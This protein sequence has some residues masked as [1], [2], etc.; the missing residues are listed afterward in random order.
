MAISLV[1][2]VGKIGAA[3]T[4]ITTGTLGTPATAGNLLVAV[5]SVDKD[6]GG[7]AA[8]PSDWAALA[9]RAGAS[10]SLQVVA[11][12]AAGG[13]TA[14]TLS[15]T[16]S[17]AAT[18]VIAEFS[19]VDPADPF[20]PS[21]FPAY[22]D[23][24]STGVTL[25]PGPAE[26]AGAALVAL[27]VDSGPLTAATGPGMTNRSS[28]ADVTGAPGSALLY[29]TDIAAG[30]DL[31]PAVY[32][33]PAL[34]DQYQGF[35]VLLNA[36]SASPQV[37]VPGV[38][39]NVDADSAEAVYRVTGTTSARLVVSTASD[40]SS[41]VY[42]TAVGPDP[43][44]AVKLPVAGLAADTLYHYGVELNGVL[45]PGFRGSFRTFPSSAPATFRFAMSSCLRTDLPGDV[46]DQVRAVS[47]RFFIE[48]GDF[49]YPDY[50]TNDPGR[51][52]DHYDVMLA[53][54]K[55]AA[56][57]A[58]FPFFYAF[59][60]H[61]YGNDSA[62]A[63]FGPNRDSPSRPAVNAAYRERFPHY[64]L[65]APGGIGIYQTFTYGPDV[66]FIVLDTRSHRSPVADPDDATKTMLGTEQ[67]QWFKDTVAAATESLIF[68]VSGVPWAGSAGGGED[69]WGYYAT[70]R[71]ELIAYFG[72]IGKLGRL[73]AL[74]GDMHAVAANDGSTSPG[75]IPTFQA[76]PLAQ[77]GS[78]KGGPWTHGP[79]QGSTT[80]GQF[81]YVDVT[82]TASGYDVRF[83]G[84][85]QS[86]VDVLD[87][88][89][90]IGSSA[91]ST[92]LLRFGGSPVDAVRVGS[93]AASKAYVGA[94]QVWP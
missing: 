45:Q 71:S 8:P 16:N 86:G 24:A 44:G 93:L 23:S 62:G 79:V 78:V 54:P 28:G 6:S 49:G 68:F 53:K 37:V 59:D 61:D 60:D 29:R 85:N 76:A 92:P 77:G 32:G 3:A 46:F 1:Q 25:D 80:N 75:N 9:G 7:F 33:D 12:V 21:H 56:A 48:H 66:R 73:V 15:W 64:P 19:G 39:G 51:F 42:G 89:V 11:K 2:S 41:P 30:Q 70:E 87:L 84:R 27:A 35:I 36:A 81:G 18:S 14:V 57:L 63:S 83:R 50:D 40:L 55:V 69:D 20:G 65:P 52:R 82:A 13:E 17:R 47:P 5:T 91:P 4:S 74:A 22:S 67:K 34:S 58:E 26:A 38:I 72:S 31:A 90:A 94:T 88:T 43:R 10:V